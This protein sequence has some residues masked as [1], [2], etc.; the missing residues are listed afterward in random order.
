MKGVD[1]VVGGN[2]GHMSAFMAPGR[3]A[4]GLRRRRRRPRRLDLRGPDLRHGHAWRRSAPTAS[5]SRCATS[6]C[7]ELGGAARRGRPR[8]TTPPSF[9]R[10]GSA[11]EP[12]PLP[13]RQ[14]D[15]VLSSTHHGHHL[16]C[17]G[18]AHRPRPCPSS[19][20]DSDCA[21]P[22]PS[23]APPSPTSSAPPTPAS[24]TSAAGAPSARSR[25]STT[26]CSSARRMSRY[27]LEGYREKCDTDVVA[28]RPARQVPAAPA[29]SRS[30]SPA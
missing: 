3:P 22:R 9:T 18:T 28:R 21:S 6:T 25:T 5:R 10:Y 4:G 20:D 30:P 24:T 26:C 8:P 7:A 2:I 27:P 17:P 1:I 23:T 19:L 12:L 15:V 16:T 11:R 14:L 13:R 29:T